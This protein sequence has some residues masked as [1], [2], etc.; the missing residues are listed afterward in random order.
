[1]RKI[2]FIL[3]CFFAVTTF[4]QQKK[5]TK[6]KAK[7]NTLSTSNKKQAVAKKNPAKKSEYVS[8][9]ACY[10]GGK[11]NRCNGT[12]KLMCWDHDGYNVCDDEEL[13]YYS[14]DDEPCSETCS[15]CDSYKPRIISCYF[16]VALG[17]GKCRE[18][19]GTGKIKKQ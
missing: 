15:L 9:N 11:C 10:G 4:A 1:M 3:F 8:C 12:A 14:E 19:N 18:C 5:T 6:T 16:C 17:S 7:T 2:I 13:A